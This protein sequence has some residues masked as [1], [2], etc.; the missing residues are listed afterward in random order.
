M[1]TCGQSISQSVY[2]VQTLAAIYRNCNLLMFGILLSA[3]L[4]REASNDRQT[5]CLACVYFQQFDLFKETSLQ[6]KKKSVMVT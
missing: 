6:I 2:R 4:Q 5:L 3:Y 1:F